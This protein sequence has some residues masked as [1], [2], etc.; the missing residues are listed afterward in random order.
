MLP[1]NS[2]D[3]ESAWETLISE[4]LHSDQPIETLYNPAL[5]PADMLPYLAWALSVDSWNPS[6]PD[7]IKR[8]VIAAA[9]E[10][11]RIKGTKAAVI[12]ALASLNIEADYAEWH[13]TGDAPG[14]FQITAFVRDNLDAN[15]ETLL[16]AQVINDVRKYID[17]VKRGS[18]HYRLRT[19]IA[20]TVDLGIG[21]A[22]AGGTSSLSIDRQSAPD[23]VLEATVGLSISPHRGISL[24]HL[25]LAHG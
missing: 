21:T 25:E 23:M 4:L 16:N 13:E 10:L 12:Q 2:S 1:P 8:Q 20:Q 11:H 24:N 15:G 9:P 6:W 5:C 17:N 7:T 3:F 18:Q 22:L 14:T 19:G